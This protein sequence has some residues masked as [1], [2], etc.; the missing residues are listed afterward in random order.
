VAFGRSVP[1]P[2][3]DPGM[4]TDQRAH[5]SGPSRSVRLAR[6]GTPGLAAISKAPE[7]AGRGRVAV[8]A[9]RECT[10]VLDYLVWLLIE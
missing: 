4:Y 5:I 6:V 9:G 2:T 3:H 8:V 1:S 7:E 10:S